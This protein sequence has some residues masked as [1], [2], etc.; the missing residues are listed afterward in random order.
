MADNLV[1]IKIPLVSEDGLEYLEFCRSEFGDPSFV[2]LKLSE[3]V[4]MRRK[5]H[6]PRRWF[7]DEFLK[8]LINA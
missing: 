2:T 6:L 7:K 8:G 4:C 5:I 3:G 1:S